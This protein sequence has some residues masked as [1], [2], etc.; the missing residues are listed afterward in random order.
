[1][2][3]VLL[4]VGIIVLPAAVLLAASWWHGL[5]KGVV[6]AAIGVGVTVLALVTYVAI[7]WF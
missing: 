7:V 6:L 5:L 3:P 4:I 1:M 2:L